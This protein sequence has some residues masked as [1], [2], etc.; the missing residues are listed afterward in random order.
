M[1]I[2]SNHYD[3]AFEDYLRS[4]RVPY[5]CV[6]ER[7][8]ALLRNASLK[9]MDFIVYSS[10]GRNLLVDVKGRRFP[11][12]PETGRSRW[13]NWATSDDLDSLLEWEQV[14]GSDFRAMLVFAYHIIDPACSTEFDRIYSH[15][16][17]QYAFFG[18]WV[19][20]YREQMRPRSAKWETVSVPMAEY[21]RLRQPVEQFLGGGTPGRSET[22]VQ[23]SSTED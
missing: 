7:R 23:H 19:D 12:A 4:R 11:T 16:N 10:T 2:R 22:E 6:D 5:V 1:G 3:L 13:V 20:E 15:P 21:H 17:G 18:V 14:F 8:R 9:S